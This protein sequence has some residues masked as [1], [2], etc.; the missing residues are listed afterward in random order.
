MGYSS[1]HIETGE[2]TEMVMEME[3][4]ERSREM[5]KK[6]LIKLSKGYKMKGYRTEKKGSRMTLGFLAYTSG[7]I[8]LPFSDMR[9]LGNR[10]SFRD[11]GWKKK[12]HG[13]VFQHT[14]F[15]MMLKYS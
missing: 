4:D 1:S 8:V 11:Q 6:K 3:R 13:F 5:L 14:K 9:N 7:W 12:G 10:V 15:E 2:E